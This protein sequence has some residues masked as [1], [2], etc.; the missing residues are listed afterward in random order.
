MLIAD[1]EADG[2]WPPDAHADRIETQQDYQRL[3]RNRRD[4]VIQRWSADL[5][6]WHA[7]EDEFIPYPAVKVAAR[8][9]AAFLFGEDPSYGHDDLKVREAIDG[10]SADLVL[11]ARLLEGAITQAVQGEV[12]LRPAWDA[13]ISR[14]AIIT[15]VPGAQV[16]PTFRYG[17]LA[18]ATIVTEYEQASG[19]TVTVWRHLE[20]HTRGLIRHRL[21]RGRSDRL[22]E[23][24]D[25]GQRPETRGLTEEV[26]TRI[27]DLLMIHVPLLRDADSPHGMSLVDGL[28]AITLALHRLYSQEQHDAEIVRRRIAVS[29]E[30]LKRDAD[31]GLYYPRTDDLF[32]LSEESGGAVGEGDAKPV[33]PIEFSDDNVMRERIAG[34]LRDFYIACGISPSTILPEREGTA[35]SGTARKLAQAT[36]IQTVSAAGRYWADAVAVTLGLALAVERLHLNRTD[37]PKIE[38][39]PSV[40]LADGLIDDPAELARIIADLDSAGALSVDE[41]VRMLH[42]EWTEDEIAV[43]VGRIQAERGGPPSPPATDALGRRPPLVPPFDEGGDGGDAE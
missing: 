12:Y 19:G 17:L 42:P 29:E 21:F 13:D 23:R 25:L 26:R 20:E 5:P 24:A 16:L 1:L 2:A 4:E 36:T 43:E 15:C 28:E 7:R 10:L 8:T 33:V 11:P 3:Y 38:V 34:R 41:K 9:L 27:D 40:T 30:Y 31:G 35:E 37:H 14:R 22:G 6:G 32:I 39:L 18:D